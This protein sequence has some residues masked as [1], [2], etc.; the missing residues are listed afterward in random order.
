MA[1]G[2]IPLI[3]RALEKKKRIYEYTELWIAVE[4]KRR[5]TGNQAALYR[6]ESETFTT[7]GLIT[8]A[9]HANPNGYLESSEASKMFCRKHHTFSN[10]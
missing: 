8:R 5:W 4:E 1:F 2:T 10:T 6:E 7:H 3:V 9:N